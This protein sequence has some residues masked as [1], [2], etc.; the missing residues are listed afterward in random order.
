MWSISEV[1]ER[2]KAAFKNNYWRC[3]LVA[4]ILGILSAGSSTTGQ[5]NSIKN[6]DT[7]QIPNEQAAAIVAFVASIIIIFVIVWILLRIFLLNPL[8]VG[9][10]T[11]LKKNITETPDLSEL[12]EGYSDYKRVV[13]TI[14]LRDV[15]LAL[16]FCLLVI[17]GIIK[18]YSY[19]MVPFIVKDEPE[20]S[21]REVINRSREMMNG[22]K[23]RAFLLHLS[24][25][26]W[27]LLSLITCGLVG[28]FY[29]NPYMKSSTAA[30]YL[31]LKDNAQA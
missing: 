15:F 18:S 11:F 14:L 30:L 6:T 29:A 20:L 23:W 4:L 24:F 27:F 26:G 8:E 3:V 21:P 5:A 25:I 12:K 19:L 1:K 22:H 9:C 31:E 17:P 10:Y 2:G 13:L 16:W 28:I 7:S